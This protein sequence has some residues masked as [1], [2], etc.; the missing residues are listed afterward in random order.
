MSKFK[1]GDKVRVKDNPTFASGSRAPLNPGDIMVVSDGEPDY[2]GDIC[3]YSVDSGDCNWDYIH[4]DS[5]E[6]VS[7]PAPELT[8]GDRVRVYCKRTEVTSEGVVREIELRDDHKWLW[9]GKGYDI[10]A[11][12]NNPDGYEFEVVERAKRWPDHEGFIR[13]TGGELAGKRGLVYTPAEGIFRIRLGMGGYRTE[14]V[15]KAF[16]PD[17]DFEYVEG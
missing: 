14:D 1:R 5:V 10:A 7:N 9:I 13:I 3:V 4:E 12:L 8:V 6:P 17:F 15:I 2:D 16:D 11:D